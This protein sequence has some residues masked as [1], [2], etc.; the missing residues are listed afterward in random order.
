MRLLLKEVKENR[1]IMAVFAKKFYFCFIFIS[2]FSW[3]KRTFYAVLD[4]LQIDADSL[5]SGR[6]R[7]N[8]R[9][10]LLLL[11]KN[12]FVF[13]AEEQ[14]RR[15]SLLYLLKKSEHYSAF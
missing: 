9:N 11:E 1:Q 8:R 3:T 10:N 13:L 15:C 4:F 6:R 2:L 14:T 5:R 12:Q 7:Y